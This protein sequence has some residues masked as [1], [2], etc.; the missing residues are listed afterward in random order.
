MLFRNLSRAFSKYRCAMRPSWF[1]KV[2]IVI[3]SLAVTMWIG[4]ASA[5]EAKSPTSINRA[6]AAIS[7]QGNSTRERVEAEIIRLHPNGFE[8]SEITRGKGRFILHVENRTVLADVSFSLNHE[9]G[10]LQRGARLLK[11]RKWVEMID[12]P[13]GQYVLTETSRPNWS[14]R[15]TITP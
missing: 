3:S 13:P 4:L 11:K 6:E 1:S 5:S 8:P 9:A 12:L 15:I 10:G 14:C 2:F 7:Q